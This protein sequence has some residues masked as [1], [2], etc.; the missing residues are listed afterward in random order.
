MMGSPVG[1]FSW[2]SWVARDL[3]LFMVL[4][5]LGLASPWPSE[6]GTENVQASRPSNSPAS[7]SADEQAQSTKDR[8]LARKVRRAIV[9]DRSLSMHAHNIKIIAKNGTVT[10]KG[11]VRSEQEKSAV[12]AKANQIAG[13]NSVK[14]EL[15]VKPRS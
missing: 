6:Q 12:T 8:E 5:A 14:D 7:P 15:T 1:K 10:L 4:G 2:P 9:A 3:A 11:A 13:A